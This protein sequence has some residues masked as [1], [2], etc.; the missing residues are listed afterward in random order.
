MQS[1]ATMSLYFK[2]LLSIYTIY[3]TLCSFCNGQNVNLDCRYDKID[4]EC[5]KS[6]Q[7]EVF[8]IDTKI[9]KISDWPYLISI[10]MEANSYGSGCYK[11]I[12]AG[13]LISPNV[14]VTAA[15]CMDYQ[16]VLGPIFDQGVPKLQIYVTRAPKCRHQTGGQRIEVEYVWKQQNWTLSTGDSDIAIIKIKE[17]FENFN[18]PYI[19]FKSSLKIDLEKP[20]YLTIVG[21][22]LSSEQEL[23]SPTQYIVAPLKQGN[24]LYKSYEICYYLLGQFGGQRQRD[25][26]NYEV[27]MCTYVEGAET[28]NGD[29][30]GP[31]VLKGETPQDDVLV[32]IVSW[33]PRSCYVGAEVQ[34][35]QVYTRVSQFVEWIDELID[36]A[37]EDI[38]P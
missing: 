3:A 19:D 22:G 33:G 35:P 14:V 28:C 17:P 9:A 20:Q 38:V 2:F 34:D 18:G 12:C 10:Q 36:Q 5:L 25:G 30:G 7:F 37:G 23:Q 4:S 24:V 29:S 11:H 1:Q 16:Q 32:G 27:M 13:M 6:S 8:G 31:L 15:H 21:W 26:L